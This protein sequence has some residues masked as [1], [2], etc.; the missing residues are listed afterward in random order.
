MPKA[1][2][3]NKRVQ[4]IIGQGIEASDYV[5]TTTPF[6]RAK[7]S[8]YYNKPIEKILLWP[9]LASNNWFGK[10]FVPEAKK[11]NF[12]MHKRKKINALFTGGLNHLSFECKCK[13]DL[14]DVEDTILKLGDTINFNIMSGE[15]KRIGEFNGKLHPVGFSDIIHFPTLYCQQCSDVMI[16]PLIDSDFNRCKSNIKVLEAALLGIVPFAQRL[17]PY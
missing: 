15:N 2:F 13:D 10:M 1:I 16:A 14:S 11:E 5:I 4:D 7:L 3:C 17:E 8:E 6:L 9:N 12:K